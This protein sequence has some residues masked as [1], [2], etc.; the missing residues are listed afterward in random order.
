MPPPA[1]AQLRPD[2]RLGEMSD[3]QWN[4]LFEHLIAVL[5]KPPAPEVDPVRVS[6]FEHTRLPAAPVRLGAG[7]LNSPRVAPP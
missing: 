2:L 6:F 3:A 4:V 5:N 7:T 1:R